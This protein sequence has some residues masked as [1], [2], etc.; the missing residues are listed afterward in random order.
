MDQTALLHN[1]NV[2]TTV[3]DFGVCGDFD[4]MGFRSG[5]SPADFPGF[6]DGPLPDDPAEGARVEAGYVARLGQYLDVVA[7]DQRRLAMDAARQARSIDA[8]R[9]WSLV[10][11]EFVLR[12]P[13]M[14]DTDRAEWAHRIFVHEIG[15]LLRVPQPTASRLIDESRIRTGAASRRGTL[16]TR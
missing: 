12:N 7:V 4:P 11:D 2:D 16:R 15:A 9:M 14:S 13:R 8:A 1:P 10:S 6:V 3:D 5:M